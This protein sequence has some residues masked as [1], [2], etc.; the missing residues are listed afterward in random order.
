MLIGND[1]QLGKDSDMGNLEIDK[2]EIKSAIKIN[3]L[4]LTTDKIYPG[5][6]NI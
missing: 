2:D 1:K 4:G 3:C 6:K 5:A